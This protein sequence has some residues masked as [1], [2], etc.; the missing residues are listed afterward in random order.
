MLVSV[1][2]NNH[3]YGRYLPYCLDSVIAQSHAETE[4]IVY[5]DCSSD[6]S[7]SVLNQYSDRVR[8]IAGTSHGPVP[9]LNQANAIN[10][11]FAVATGEVI[12][13]LDSD[14]AFVPD[15]VERVLRRFDD[16]PGLVLVQHPFVEIDAAGQPTGKVV[17]LLKQVE[18][19]DYI[20]R[21]NNL[22]GVFSQTSGLCFRRAYLDRM[23][24]LEPDQ[25]DRIWTDVRLTRQAVFHGNIATCEQP[26][27][28]YRRH[29]SNDSNKLLN[30]DYYR[31]T[32]IQMY[33]FFN[34]CAAAH[35][36][37]AIRLDHSV[38]RLEWSALQKLCGYALSREPVREKIRF[39][40][41]LLRNAPQ[42]LRS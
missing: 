5:D 17:P 41:E 35:G 34:E 33:D 38:N 25:Y 36:R 18:P 6:D 15:K 8:I 9:A 32:M 11:A 19:L 29:E 39:Y 14:D 24:P 30:S 2:I 16:D 27:G 22:A 4:I 3:N 7:R 40:R 28:Y 23:L 10:S 26:L 13:L 21:T 31:K 12:C 20:Y 42:R 1:L 37:P